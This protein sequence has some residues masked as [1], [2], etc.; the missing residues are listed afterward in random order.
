MYHFSR[1]VLSAILTL[2]LL[3]IELVLSHFTH[4]LTLL[5]LAN[6][7]M[8]NLLTLVISASTIIVSHPIYQVNLFTIPSQ[9]LVEYIMM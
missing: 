7:S 1:L 4:C 9:D 6:Q 3:E 5:A 2:V 8:Y